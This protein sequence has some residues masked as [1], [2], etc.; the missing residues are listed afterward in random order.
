MYF[1]ETYRSFV[2]L[3]MVSILAEAQDIGA[4]FTSETAA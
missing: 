4:D 1:V 2:V 3:V